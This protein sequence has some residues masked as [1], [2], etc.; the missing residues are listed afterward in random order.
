[1]TR[2]AMKRRNTSAEAGETLADYI[3]SSAPPISL[4]DRETLRAAQPGRAD[5][6]LAYKPRSKHPAA[7]ELIELIVD[8]VLRLDFRSIGS[9]RM[10]MKIGFKYAVHCVTAY[11]EFDPARHLVEA[12]IQRWALTSTANQNTRSSHVSALRRL[13]RG[14]RYEPKF[15]RNVAQPPYT[16]SEWEPLEDLCVSEVS[17][18][19]TTILA[20]AGHLG[21]RPQEVTAATG[22]WVHVDGPRTW[23][24]VPDDDGVIRMV[25]AFGFTAEWLRRRAGVGPDYLLRPRRAK[26]SMLAEVVSTL[27]RSHGEMT[28]FRVYYARHMF[29]ANMLRERIPLRAIYSVAGL[30]P[31]STLPGDLMAYVA[32]PSPEAIYQSMARSFSQPIGGLN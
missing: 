3:S 20:L 31:G 13:R 23:L 12:N 28:G 4:G 1:M 15:S 22:N 11:G 16:D 29:V 18:D 17:P 2:K 24:T 8:L 21:L 30:S 5:L 7:T 19:A 27:S 32:E 10:Q 26:R 25:P 6:L 9:D 14:K